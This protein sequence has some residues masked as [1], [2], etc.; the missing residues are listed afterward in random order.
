MTLDNGLRVFL[1]EDHELP[2]VRGTLLMR[3]GHRAAPP[4]RVGAPARPPRPGRLPRR[5]G[6]VT[7][8]EP[9]PFAGHLYMLVLGCRGG[10]KLC[11][12]PRLGPSVMFSL[13]VLTCGACAT[14]QASRVCRRRCSGGAGQNRC[15]GRSWMRPWSRS[16]RTL[17][18]GP[19]NRNIQHTTYKVQHII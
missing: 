1:A 10:R 11:L 17:R 9:G 6:P 15:R 8:P 5:R 7:A 18:C 13:F 14:P 19:P 12:R 4:S 16:P 3:G 2:L